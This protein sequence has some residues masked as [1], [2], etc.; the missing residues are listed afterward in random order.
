[1]STHRSRRLRTVAYDLEMDYNE[2]DDWG[3]LQLLKGF[4]LFKRGGRKRISNILSREDGLEGL[5][6]NIFDYRYVISTGKSAKRFR[7]TVFFVQSKAL[8]LP[9]F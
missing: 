7:Q 2:K 9:E 6:I 8:F 3:L 5:K 1:M 4:H